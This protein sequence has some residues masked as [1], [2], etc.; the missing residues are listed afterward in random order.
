MRIFIITIAALYLYGCGALPTKEENERTPEKGEVGKPG[1]QGPAGS[2]CSV[3]DT[4]TG[5]IIICENGTTAT[6]NN[7]KDGTST[8][9][10]VSEIV[11]EGFVCGKYAVSVGEKVYLIHGGMVLLGDN[12]Y[13]VKKNCKVRYKAAK[14]EEKKS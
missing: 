8:T 2:S 4:D 7:G 6:I 12:W 5:A 10:K 9:E 11:L 14:L 13:E 1:E 3:S